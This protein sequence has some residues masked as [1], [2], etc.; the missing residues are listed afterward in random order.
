MS[1]SPIVCVCTP[2]EDDLLG[3]IQSL[4]DARLHVVAPRDGLAGDLASAEGL[5]IAG[6][7]RVTREL[8]D[9]APRLRVVA[10][11]SVGFDHIDLEAAA[12][13]GVAVC[14]TPG[15]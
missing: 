1:A 7:M 2:L 10:S 4:C 5:L 15:Y 11:V 13:R 12:E 6:P 9:A 3:L 8:I 14:N